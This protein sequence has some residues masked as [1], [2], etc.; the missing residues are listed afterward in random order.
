MEKN[1]KEELMTTN[2]LLQL[3]T[4]QYLRDFSILYLFYYAANVTFMKFKKI[5]NPF[6]MM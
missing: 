2:Y 5:L 1:V 3:I 6:I 4:Q